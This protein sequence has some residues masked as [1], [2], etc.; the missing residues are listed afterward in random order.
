MCRKK[1]MP[2]AKVSEE[3]CIGCG[4]CESMCPKVFKLENGKS[5]VIAEDCIECDCKE[6]ADSCPTGAISVE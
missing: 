4:T 6:V 2:K 5:H 3:L 1:D